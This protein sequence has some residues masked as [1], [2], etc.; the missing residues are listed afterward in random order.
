MAHRVLLLLGAGQNI[1]LASITAFK[2]QGYKVA[3]ASRTPSDAI[4]K[5][6]DLV[7]T[8]DFSDPS[9]VADLFIKVEAEL[10]IPNVVIY[11]GNDNLFGASPIF[12]DLSLAYCWIGRAT[13]PASPTTALITGFQQDLAVNTVSA[14]AAAQAAVEGF[15]RLP[16]NLP[17]TFIFTGNKGAAAISPAVFTL[18]LTKAS[19]WYMIQ[20]LAEA[21]KDKGY[22]FYFVDE[23]TPEGKGMIYIS[24]SA[25]AT[26]F[27]ELAQRKAQG[28]AFVAFVRGK[29]E[30]R[31]EADERAKLPVLKGEELAD[32][33]YGKP[34]DVEG[35]KW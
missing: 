28:E 8:A 25:H 1:G 35:V 13:D 5:A 2:A 24:G 11:N 4:R 33:G 23:R 19:T 9:C 3:S 17:K 20:T 6:A 21:Y 32:F 30:V 22:G 10:G 29:G 14:Y 18:G 31:F 7:L 27:L 16:P 26:M 12:A 34:E 15:A